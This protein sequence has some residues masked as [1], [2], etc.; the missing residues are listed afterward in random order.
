MLRMVTA[1]CVGELCNSE[2]YIAVDGSSTWQSLKARADCVAL[3]S[4]TNNL[5]EC[6]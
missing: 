5:L 2:L 4:C 6:N 1:G 3:S